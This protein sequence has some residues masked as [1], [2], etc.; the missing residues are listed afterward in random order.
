MK[1]G[2]VMREMNSILSSIRHATGQPNPKQLAR[3]D[4]LKLAKRRV[5]SGEIL[6]H[7]REE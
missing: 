5:Q 3:L 4:E 2:E 7:R 1:L 6:K